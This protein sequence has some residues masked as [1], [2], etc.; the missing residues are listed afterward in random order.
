MHWVLGLSPVPKVSGCNIGPSYNR[1]QNFKTGI[2]TD[3]IGSGPY[4]RDQTDSG[5]EIGYLV[6]L[7]TSI[8]KKL[9]INAHLC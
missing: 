7:L 2:K 3:L 1:V 5:S 4:P 6:F 9:D 8:S